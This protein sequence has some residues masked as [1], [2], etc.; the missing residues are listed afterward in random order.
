MIAT[1]VLDGR[2]GA[3]RGYE[4][5]AASASSTVVAGAWRGDLAC[6]ATTHIG[7]RKGRAVRD[8]GRVC[9]E[10]SC[11]A[12]WERVN[13]APCDVLRYHV[14]GDIDVNDG[15]AEHEDGEGD[16]RRDARQN[17]ER[18]GNDEEEGN[19]ESVDGIQDRHCFFDGEG[20]SVVCLWLD[21][22]LDGLCSGLCC[23]DRARRYVWLC[24][25]T[26]RAQ[27]KTCD[28]CCCWC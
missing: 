19:E 27:L 8:H 6:A 9:D 15:D 17:G 13:A 23:R 7:G 4:A 22:W 2:N 10:S 1:I 21:G 5:G 18:D 20:G 12:S 14:D 3:D 26:C 28:T 16:G 11:V 24:C 25:L